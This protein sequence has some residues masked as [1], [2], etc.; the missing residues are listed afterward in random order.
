LSEERVLFISMSTALKVDI[1]T[2]FPEMIKGFLSASILGRAIERNTLYIQVHNIRDWATDKNKTTDDRPFGGGAGMVLRPEPVFA[3]VEQLCTQH[4][5]V[6][7]MSPDGDPLTSEY[8]F[9]LSTKKHL[10]L[11]S[12]HYEGIDQ[13]IRDTLVD[14]EISIGD[15]VLTNGTLPSAV[16][17]D[18]VSRY[19]PNVLGKEKSLTQESFTDNLLAFPQ[20]TRPADFRGM[21]VPEVLLS[22]DHK[23]ISQWRNQ[24]RKQK[25]KQR[26]PDLI[27]KNKQIQNETHY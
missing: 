11:I 4:S 25:T 20:Y 10:I 18:A 2:L 1:L 27:T 21:T 16:L 9:E 5:F 7:Y 12:G 13:R 19:I 23:A 17:L 14:K 26:R 24:R 6:I 22:G 3:A 8:A 15:Y